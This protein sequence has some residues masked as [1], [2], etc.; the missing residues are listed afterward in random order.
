MRVY[1]RLATKGKADFSIVS[2]LD[3]LSMCVLVCM[4][5]VVYERMESKEERRNSETQHTHTHMHA[6][7][8]ILEGKKK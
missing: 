2:S 8:K 3:S 7:R 6:C 1:T 4:C 5:V